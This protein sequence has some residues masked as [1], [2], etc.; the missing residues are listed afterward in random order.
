MD[1]PASSES[2]GNTSAQNVDLEQYGAERPEI[3]NTP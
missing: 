3:A 1:S 2:L